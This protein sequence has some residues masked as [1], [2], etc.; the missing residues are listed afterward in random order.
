MLGHSYEPW[1]RWKTSVKQAFDL[2]G[3]LCG[4]AKWLRILGSD[5][6]LS[7]VGAVM[8]SDLCHYETG[9]GPSQQPEGLRRNTSGAAEAESWNNREYGPGPGAFFSR[10]LVCN[11]LVQP[12][13]T[14][15]RQAKSRT[16]FSKRFQAFMNAPVAD[17]Y[18]GKALIRKGC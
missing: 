17:A 15:T 4:L 8:G 7:A 9:L 14:G 12:I 13:P 10:C 11:A 2:E 16:G 6:C 3:N 18:T 5:D 1:T